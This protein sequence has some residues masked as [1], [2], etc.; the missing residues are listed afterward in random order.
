M[1]GQLSGNAQRRATA[2]QQGQKESQMGAGEQDSERKP[3]TSG[4]HRPAS[5]QT[6]F[7]VRQA[8]LGPNS[9]HQSDVK[10]A[11]LLPAVAPI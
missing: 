4:K 2:G 5:K 6:T 1:H 10:K 9:G 8:S 7:G 11:L 3:Q